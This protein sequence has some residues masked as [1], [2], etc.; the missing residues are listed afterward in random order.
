MFAALKKNPKTTKETP[1]KLKRPQFL[2][3]YSNVTYSTVVRVRL[4][5]SVLYFVICEKES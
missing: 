2:I 5:E 3:F 4:E 1:G